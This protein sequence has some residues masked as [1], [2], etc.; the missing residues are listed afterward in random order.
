MNKDFKV[1]WTSVQGKS[2]KKMEPQIPCQ[3]AFKY[4]KIKIGGLKIGGL[5][6]PPLHCHS[7]F[8]HVRPRL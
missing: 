6:L 7:G 3:D 2:H 8:S 5:D 1:A 4:D